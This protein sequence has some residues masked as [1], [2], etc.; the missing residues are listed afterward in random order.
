MRL[1][2]LTN[3]PGARTQPKRLG[4]GMSSGLGK[5]G[6]KGHK[7]QMAR[8]GH[9]RKP[10]FE[11]GQMPLLRRMPKRGFNN[12]TRKNLTPVNV[13]SLNRFEEGAEIT[14]PVLMRSGLAKQVRDGIKILGTGR[15]ERKLTVR[16]NAFSTAAREK[17][18]AAGGVCETV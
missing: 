1:H 14:V 10:G 6:G 9:K 15:L 11:G 7:G 17:I 16:A 5:T 8:K 3:A 12:P 13:G 2:T 4:R 18:E